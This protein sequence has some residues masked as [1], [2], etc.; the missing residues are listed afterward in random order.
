MVIRS[1]IQR[2]QYQQEIPSSPLHISSWSIP[3]IHLMHHLSQYIQRLCIKSIVFE[4]KSIPLKAW[5]TLILTWFFFFG[6]R[7]G[8]F[9]EME[10]STWRP[11]ASFLESQD[12]RRRFKCTCY[13][14]PLRQ[15][16]T[17]VEFFHHAGSPR[18]RLPSRSAGGSWPR[19]SWWSCATSGPCHATSSC[20][21]P[22]Q[23]VREEFIV[24]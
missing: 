23:T 24:K 12:W 22:G 16:D 10:L 7:R 11:Q 1:T 21:T 17:I 2:D 5:H 20:R 3:V 19:T 4:R 6:A 18:P 8:Q 15:L 9:I 13:Y 14:L